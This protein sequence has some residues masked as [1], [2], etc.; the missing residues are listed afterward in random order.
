[1]K[2]SQISSQSI[3]I[4]DV[5]P[6]LKPTFAGGL[7]FA[8]NSIHNI[9]IKDIG[10]ITKNNAKSRYTDMMKRMKNGDRVIVSFFEKFHS[11]DHLLVF[12]VNEL[13]L[14]GIQD[15]LYRS[16]NWATKTLL[17]HE[18]EKFKF[19]SV[20]C[21]AKKSVFVLLTPFLDGELIAHDGHLLTSANFDFIPNDMHVII[22]SLTTGA[23]SFMF[24]E[25][26]IIDLI[27]SEDFA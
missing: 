9:V 15:K 5:C 18:V 16:K 6:A 11:P 13:I 17:K 1:M 27:D 21:E 22:L 10:K 24:S 19:C 26:F 8:S 14:V 23:A 4:G 2:M 12:N 20:H 7:F 25:S 3:T